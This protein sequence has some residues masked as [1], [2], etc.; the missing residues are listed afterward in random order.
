MFDVN[1]ALGGNA[2]SVQRI[3]F[4]NDRLTVMAFTYAG[5]MYGLCWSSLYNYYENG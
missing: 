2:D 4:N 1:Y 5:L 3:G